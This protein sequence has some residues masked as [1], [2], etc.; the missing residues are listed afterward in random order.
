MIVDNGAG[1]RPSQHVHKLV[2]ETAVAMCHELYDTM[3]LDNQWYSQWKA[4]NQDLAG[5]PRQLTA[6]FVT[7]NLAKV[8][9]QARATL[10]GMLSRTTDPE[11]QRTI[12]DALLLD[13]TLLRGRRPQ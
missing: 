2:H 10:A 8:I 11:L 1:N 6:R 4:Q 9:P 12:Y 7:K 13:N 5:Q 3:M